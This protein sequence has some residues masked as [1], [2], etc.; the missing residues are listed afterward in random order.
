MPSPTGIKVKSISFIGPEKNFSGYV[1]NESM[2]LKIVSF[3]CSE[4]PIKKV[5]EESKI[6]NDAKKIEA[7]TIKYVKSSIE[8]RFTGK[9]R[10]KII[11]PYIKS[12]QAD[13]SDNEVPAKN[14][15]FAG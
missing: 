10:I 2:A 15:V 12:P 14:K 1:E 4:L 11:Y 8:R 13:I 9:N 3:N 6:S 5:S 7:N